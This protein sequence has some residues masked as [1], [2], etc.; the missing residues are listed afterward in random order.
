MRPFGILASRYCFSL[1]RGDPSG[2]ATALLAT[3]A[4]LIGGALAGDTGTPRRLTS[5]STNAT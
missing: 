5:F 3:G 4:A 2:A 1:P